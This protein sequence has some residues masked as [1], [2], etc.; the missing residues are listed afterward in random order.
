MSISTA[1]LANLPLATDIVV[2]SSFNGVPSFSSV[3]LMM[4]STKYSVG[5]PRRQAQTAIFSGSKGRLKIGYPSLYNNV[6]IE[7]LPGVFHQNMKTVSLQ[8]D[9]NGITSKSQVY[10]LHSTMRVPQTTKTILEDGK[11]NLTQSFHDQSFPPL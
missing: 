7:N 4:S 9:F 3:A 11:R 10:E 6:M 8:I 2:L 5:R 1:A